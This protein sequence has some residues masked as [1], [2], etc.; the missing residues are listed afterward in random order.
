LGQGSSRVGADLAVRDVRQAIAFGG[1]QAP[2]GCAK[3]GIEPDEDQ[4]SFSI[5]SSGTS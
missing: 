2:T 3:A 1:D 5:T 4:P